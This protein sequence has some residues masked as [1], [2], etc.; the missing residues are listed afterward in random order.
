LS[1]EPARED[2][3][4]RVTRPRPRG[5]R[6]GS[7]LIATG[8]V[9]ATWLLLAGLFSCVGANYEGPLRLLEPYRAPTGDEAAGLIPIDYAINNDTANDVI[10]IGDSSCRSGL[11]PRLFERL[12]GLKAYNLGS[13][14]SLGMWAHLLTLKTYLAHHPTPRVVV[15]CVSPSS[16]LKPV[17]DRPDPFT[18]PVQTTTAGQ[19]YERFLR[20]YGPPSER[21]GILADGTASLR[22]FINRGMAISKALSKNRLAGQPY[23]PLDEPITGFAK[24]TY[25]TLRD[26]TLERRGYFPLPGE[27]AEGDIILFALEEPHVANSWMNDGVREFAALAERDHFRLL[28]RLAPMS[29]RH[30]D[31]DKDGIDRWLTQIQREHPGVAVSRPG[32]LWYDHKLCWDTIHLNPHGVEPFTAQAAKDVTALVAQSNNKSRE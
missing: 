15:L 32:I 18:I 24:E 5:R 10:F 11:D 30:A 20:V 8:C 26:K 1:Q 17:P 6:I 7:S 12:S 3:L 14:G 27:H 28:I 9:V 16:V 25:N 31:W 29:K 2:V 21:R 4:E 22:Y 13:F 23:D 19:L